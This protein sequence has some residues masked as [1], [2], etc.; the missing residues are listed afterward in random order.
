MIERTSG[1]GR[2]FRKERNMGKQMTE[3]FDAIK[4]KQA[5]ID[6][7]LENGSLIL[8]GKSAEVECNSWVLQPMY[9]KDDCSVGF[10][11]IGDKKIGPCENHIHKDAI[12][13]LIVVKGSLLLNLDGRDVRIVRE[14]EC[15]SIKSGMQHYSTP[16]ENDTKMIYACIPRDKG[17]DSVLEGLK[18]AT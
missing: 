6:T 10:V 18:N 5:T 17:M 16:L 9:Q 15:A 2:S 7:L 13:Y 14:G 8:N 3:Q 12:E 4:K 11:I 1:Q